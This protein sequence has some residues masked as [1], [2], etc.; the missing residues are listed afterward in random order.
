MKNSKLV[1][2][3]LD[4]CQ[5][6]NEETDDDARVERLCSDEHEAVWDAALNAGWTTAELD[7][8]YERRFGLPAGYVS[9]LREGR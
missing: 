5:T 8:A 6:L 7:A 4:Y 9:R 2:D 3:W 1:S